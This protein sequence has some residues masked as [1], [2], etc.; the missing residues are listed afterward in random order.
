MNY[1]AKSTSFGIYDS[2]STPS[3]NAWPISLKKNII[4]S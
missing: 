2:G 1:S 4:A 3:Q